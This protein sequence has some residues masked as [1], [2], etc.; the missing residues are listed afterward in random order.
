MTEEI[1]IIVIIIYTKHH[2]WNYCS[3]RSL[4]QVNLIISFSPLHQY[5][6]LEKLS[7][8]IIIRWNSGKFWELIQKNMVM[9]IAVLVTNMIWVV[10]AV[11]IITVGIYR[12]LSSFL[13]SMLWL[14][15]LKNHWVTR[16]GL[17]WPY[18]TMA[19]PFLNSGG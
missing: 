11:E 6:F 7:I 8:Q 3:K 14:Q 12:W 2:I 4:N 17:I 13:F 9:P 15:I 5:I 1:L 10:L 18:L 16:S 19:K